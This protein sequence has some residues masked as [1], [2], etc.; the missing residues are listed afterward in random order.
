MTS[1]SST[2]IHTSTLQTY[3]SEVTTSDLRTT[4]GAGMSGAYNLGM[5]TIF[6]LGAFFHWRVLAGV[7]AFF[8]VIAFVLL[9]AFVPESPAWYVTKGTLVA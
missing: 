9:A 7:S 5:V 6:T 4:L 8:P 3:V 1:E 2:A